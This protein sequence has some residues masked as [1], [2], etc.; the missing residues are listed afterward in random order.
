MEE[1]KRESLMLLIIMLTSISGNLSAG[2]STIQ[3]DILGD[4]VSVCPGT[5]GDV[6]FRV[7][8]SGD[9]K[10]I[11]I[12]VSGVPYGWGTQLAFKVSYSRG[13]RE[14]GS[15]D[16]NSDGDYDDYWIVSHSRDT[17]SVDDPSTRSLDYP[18]LQEGDYFS[19]GPITY[20]ILEINENYVY[21]S[22]PRGE[23]K[24]NSMSEVQLSLL[25]EV[26]ENAVSNIQVPIQT[27]TYV[28]DQ[29]GDGVEGQYTFHIG[30]KGLFSVSNKYYLGSV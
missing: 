12:S 21:F 7:T 15:I 16:L 27:T 1:L 28:I 3:I 11:S 30:R 24:M 8:N 5:S 13:F 25:V 18:S 29:G 19:L 23:L 2:A 26:P 4:T 6:M 22:V 14:G 9:E 10:T 17:I 20:R